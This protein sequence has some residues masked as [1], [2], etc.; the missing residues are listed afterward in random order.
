[1]SYPVDKD[2][3]PTTLVAAVNVAPDVCVQLGRAVETLD[4]T[5][6]FMKCDSYISK[7]RRPPFLASIQASESSI[8]FIDFD[9][10]TEQAIESAQYL[11]LTYPGKISVVALGSTRVAGNILN[12]MR[13]GCCEFL[14]LPLQPNSL[15][16]LF[17]RL[18]RKRASADGGKSQPGSVI[19]FCGVKGGV[20]VTTIATHF[21]VYLAHCHQKRTLLIDSHPA[22][23]HVAIY[24]GMNG[25]QSLFRNVVQNLHRLDSELLVGYLAEHSSGLSVLT[26]PDSLADAEP[27]NEEGVAKA[28]EFMRGEFDYVVVDCDRPTQ[29]GSAPFIEA[30][31]RLYL[32]VTPE[33]GAIRDL[34]RHIDQLA[35]RESNLDKVELI[36]NRVSRSDEIHSDQIE[37]STGRPIA[38]RVPSMGR[39]FVRACNLGTPILP[40]RKVPFTSMLSEWVAKVTGESAVS[41]EIEDDKRISA[42]K[43]TSGSTSLWKKGFAFNERH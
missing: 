13:A 4:G 25:G 11:T 17:D 40:S 39:E 29:E 26:S 14:S 42:F 2:D 8:I 31:Q 30:S 3:T 37:K 43:R 20:G 24:L 35:L 27:V 1:M 5:T 12:A 21:A 34:S 15:I 36:L 38:M 16:E 32:Q 23:G 28:L 33:V 18:D 10:S 19:S 9:R 7:M 22:L 6:S 41:E